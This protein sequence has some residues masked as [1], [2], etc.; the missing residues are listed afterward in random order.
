MV[1]RKGLQISLSPGV[2]CPIFVAIS[3]L[4]SSERCSLNPVT[5]LA[6]YAH[7]SDTRFDGWGQQKWRKKPVCGQS[8]TSVNVGRASDRWIRQKWGRLHW[9]KLKDSKDYIQRHLLYFFCQ[10]RSS[11]WR[12]RDI[13]IML[14]DL[15]TAPHPNFSPTFRPDVNTTYTSLIR[16]K[17]LQSAQHY[18]CGIVD[19][20]H[21]TI[22]LA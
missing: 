7:L 16:G 5:L 13:F 20:V 10:C 18:K 3:V 2:S 1:G 22:N 11:W 8:W 4:V 9:T 6:G 21:C 15:A 19:K 12:S 17:T 14:I